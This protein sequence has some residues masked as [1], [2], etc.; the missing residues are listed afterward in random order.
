[1]DFY[2]LNDD[3]DDSDGQGTVGNSDVRSTSDDRDVRRTRDDGDGNHS[4]V[5]NGNDVQH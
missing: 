5:Y 1:M 4:S 2:R 3:G